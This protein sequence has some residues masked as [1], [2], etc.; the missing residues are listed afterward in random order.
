M[1]IEM[2]P[3]SLLGQIEIIGHYEPNCFSIGPDINILNL[4]EKL[5]CIL[6]ET[7]SQNPLRETEFKCRGTS[8]IHILRPLTCLVR[9]WINRILLSTN[10]RKTKKTKRSWK[11]FNLSYKMYVRGER[12][13]FTIKSFDDNLRVTFNR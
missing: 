13:I 8:S 10:L 11:E 6:L 1:L 4:W 9:L 3:V 7:I 5:P 2:D 12:S